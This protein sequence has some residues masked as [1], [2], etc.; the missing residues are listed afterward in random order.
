MN[1]SEFKC[2]EYSPSITRAIIRLYFRDIYIILVRDLKGRPYK[3]LIQF[4]LKFIKEYLT[5]VSEAL[6]N[7][8]LGYTSSNPFQHYYLRYKISTD[9]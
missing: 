3:L 8:T 5:D 6:R 7:L 1:E 9:L 2:Q 4:T